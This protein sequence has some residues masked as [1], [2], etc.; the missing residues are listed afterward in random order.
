METVP[1][2]RI[3]EISVQDS[4]RLRAVEAIDAVLGESSELAEL[5]DEG[6]EG[7]VWRQSVERIRS[8]IRG[9]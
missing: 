3:Q 4:D 1:V 2:S 5:W 8:R 9:R 7:P 6:Q